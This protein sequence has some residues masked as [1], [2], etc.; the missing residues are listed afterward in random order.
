MT[1]T[2]IIYQ[3]PSQPTQLFARYVESEEAVLLSQNGE[4]VIIA[5]MLDADRPT[6]KQ[7]VL[8]ERRWPFS[9]PIKWDD[10]DEVW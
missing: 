9:L 2:L 3:Q 4:S 5:I 6:I 7:F 8:S 10:I 1:T